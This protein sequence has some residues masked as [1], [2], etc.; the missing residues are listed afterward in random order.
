M[1]IFHKLGWAKKY[2]QPKATD[3]TLKI[4][5]QVIDARNGDINILNT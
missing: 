1:T 5:S 2:P 4:K 3:F